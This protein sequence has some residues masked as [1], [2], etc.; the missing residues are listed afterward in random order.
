MKRQEYLDHL[1]GQGCTLCRLIAPWHPPNTQEI[2]IHH[3]RFAAGAGEKASDWLAIPLCRSCHLG[4][5]GIHGN[6]A[7]LEIAKTDEAGLLAATIERY[8]KT[9]E[10]SR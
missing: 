4:A 5:N 1:R 10:N 7:F 3:P 2:Q 9:E 6:R 8:H